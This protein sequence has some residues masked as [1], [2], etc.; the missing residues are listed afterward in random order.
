MNCRI[1][2]SPDYKSI[3]DLGNIYPSNFISNGEEITAKPLHLVKCQNC[4]LV[5]LKETYNLD[6][7]Y[8][9]HYWYRS[10]LNPSMVMSLEDVVESAL[11]VYSTM[12]NKVVPKYVLDIGCNDGTLLSLYPKTVL[13]VGVDPSKNVKELAEQ[14]CDVFVNDYF[15][16][17]DF[18]TYPYLKYDIITSIAM[19]YDLEF[20][21]IFLRDVCTVL[22][23]DGLWVIQ[24][25]D[26]LSM[27]KLSAFD[28]ICHEHLEYYSLS[29][30][31][32]FLAKW[33]L[34]IIDVEYNVVN[35]GSIRAYV[36]WKRKE[37]KRKRVNE[38]LE[39][40]QAYLKE[41][42][43]EEFGYTILKEKS[44][45]LELVSQI[46]EAN[47]S[48]YVLGASTK[49]NTL[50][51]HYGLNS[52]IIDKALEVNEDKFG[53]RT[54]GTNIPIISEEQGL[55]EKPDYLL[56]LPWHFRNFFIEKF[57]GYLRSGGSLIFPLPTV[58]II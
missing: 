57:D 32:N 26:L 35:G 25:T 46:K 40:E 58:E 29:V 9:D 48:I 2:S 13:K 11:K 47:K 14:H 51:Q 33:N 24:F 20:P 38:A 34:Q 55:Q 44:K 30:L 49:G 7:M 6:A 52:T 53:L 31:D 17:S 5:Q 45:L 27:L 1:C 4:N 12:N 42:P 39:L 43:I 21:N 54:I 37:Y 41:H 19:F 3:L 23:D 10:G 15:Q 18:T 16:L 56:V 8:R 36:T 22:A 50:L 28:N